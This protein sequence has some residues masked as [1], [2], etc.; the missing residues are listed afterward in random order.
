MTDVTVHDTKGSEDATLILVSTVAS[1]LTTSTSGRSVPMS[2]SLKS[3]LL[4]GLLLLFIGGGIFVI[5]LVLIRK[6]RQSK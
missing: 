3:I 2:D 1:G 6:I 4:W 5:V